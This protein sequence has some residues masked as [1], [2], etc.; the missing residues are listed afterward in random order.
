MARLDTD[1]ADITRKDVL[2]LRGKFQIKTRRGK[3][4]VAKWPERRGPPKSE[5]HRA[6]VNWF[7]CVATAF[8]SPPGFLMDSAK[9]M[10]A[11]TGW[12]YRDAMENAAAGLFIRYQSEIPIRTPTCRLE[13]RTNQSISANTDTPI[14]PNA[15]IWDN[16]QFWNATVNPG[17]MTFRNAGLYLFMATLQYK[18]AGSTFCQVQFRINGNVTP[19]IIRSTNVGTDTFLHASGIYYLHANDYM[20]LVAFDPSAGRLIQIWEWTCV[21]ISQESLIP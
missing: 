17:R 10:T 9:A 12:Y 15:A 21:G 14:I 18:N 19:D 7:K 8:K 16:Q 2:R 4:Y 13:R 20:E 6:W 11:G 5:R 3:V 1:A